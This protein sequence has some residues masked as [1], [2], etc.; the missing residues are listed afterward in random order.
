[1]QSPEALTMLVFG[2]YEGERMSI[3][4][5]IG[6]SVG[7]AKK[8]F[9]NIFGIY[10]D[11]FSKKDRKVVVLHYSG[12]DL[13]EGW[14]FT[15]LGISP[16]STIKIHMKEEI[17]PVLFVHCTYN[18]E[19]ID[20]VDK[21][22]TVH[23]MKVEDLRTIVG[24]RTGI[25]VSIF[26]LVNNE[27]HEMYDGHEL[28]NYNV[29]AGMTLRMENWDGWNEFI[30]LCIMGFTPQVLAQIS[31]D[32]VISRFQMKVALFISAHYGC[33][34]LARSLIRQGV[35]ADEHIGEHPNRQ[36]CNEKSHIE[37]KKAPIHEATENGQLGV[38][39][40]FVNH[41]ITVVMAKDGNDL[42]ALNIALRK[43]QKPCASFL[44]T[45]QWTKVP[46]GKFG[47]ITVQSLRKIKSWSIRAKERAFAKYGQTRSTLKKRS[48]TCGALVSYG[49]PVVNGFTPSPMTGKPKNEMKDKEKQKSIDTF[50][51]VYGINGDPE[52]YFRQ[53]GSLTG[54]RNLNRRRNTKWGAMIDRSDVAVQLAGG[55]GNAMEADLEAETAYSVKGQ[56]TKTVAESVV[57]DA[58]SRPYKGKRYQGAGHSIDQVAEY[59]AKTT[60]ANKN[61]RGGGKA[62]HPLDDDIG[63]PNTKLPPLSHRS[64]IQGGK[65]TIKEEDEGELSDNSM[66][67]K[68]KAKY[69][70][71]PINKKPEKS[72]KSIPSLR[73]GGG[74][75]SKMALNAETPGSPRSI[76]D[77]SEKSDK[78]SKKKNRITSS[79]LLSKAKAASEGAVPLPLISTENISRPFFYHRGLREDDVVQPI[80]D[81]VS[82]YQGSTS[83]DRAIKSMT[84]ANTFKEKAWLSQIRMAMALTTHTIR[85]SVAN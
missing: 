27:G 12:S 30:N 40:L 64:K 79:V 25:P 72:A 2:V 20:I 22:V 54:L 1:M 80:L 60:F 48:Y 55:L 67:K 15:D 23:T 58:D 33:V 14:C 81:L 41:D 32:E 68:Y 83:R 42:N 57:S 8:M 21:S 75:K 56:G 13:E 24:K 44:L 84:I 53:M 5:P 19:V 26:R 11:D 34:D 61:V 52:N 51:E 39:R 18:D 10:V 7:E 46:V 29:E 66:D 38:V 70:Q 78:K 62:D 9:Q 77:K 16:G 43:K 31:T 3:D 6:A 65:D 45:R 74:E 59:N 50:H 36:W 35:R 73:G 76:A 28:Y 69:I 71:T 4:V 47:S 63:D 37:T 82:K 17:K 49:Q 85:R